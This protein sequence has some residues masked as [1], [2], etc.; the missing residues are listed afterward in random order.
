[1][2][3][4]QVRQVSPHCNRPLRHGIGFADDLELIRHASSLGHLP[5]RILERGASAMIS[6]MTDSAVTSSVQ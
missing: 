2:A 4:P 6:A 1:M 5:G 3:V